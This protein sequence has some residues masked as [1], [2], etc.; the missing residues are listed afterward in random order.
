MILL[1]PKARKTSCSD[2]CKNARAGHGRNSGERSKATERGF[3]G[4]PTAPQGDFALGIVVVFSGGRYYY[5]MA[6]KRERGHA[7]FYR[8]E[9]ISQ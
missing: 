6:R 5:S 3:V 1:T 8:E 9:A 7:T 2:V 4:V